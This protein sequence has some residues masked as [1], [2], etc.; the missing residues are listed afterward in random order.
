MVSAASPAMTFSIPRIVSVRRN[1]PKLVVVAA[2]A[3]RS[4]VVA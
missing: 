4:S 2:P 3:A 1:P